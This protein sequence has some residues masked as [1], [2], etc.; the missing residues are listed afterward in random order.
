MAK[1]KATTKKT[2]KKKAT[3]PQLPIGASTLTEPS[4][5]E[6]RLRLHRLTAKNYAGVAGEE[7]VVDFAPDVTVFA[8]EN[9][10]L[11][12]SIIAAL[13][14]GLGIRCGTVAV[15]VDF[16]HDFVQCGLLLVVEFIGGLGFRLRRCSFGG[17]R[18]RSF[19]DFR[20]DLIKRRL[21]IFAQPFNI[22][23]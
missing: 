10:S 11:K 12:S 14:C 13:R 19:S 9:A 18:A 8:G 23:S 5:G 2:A 4:D 6:F 17:R 21:F 22:L 1:K 20:D 15:A 16:G 3:Q 7:F